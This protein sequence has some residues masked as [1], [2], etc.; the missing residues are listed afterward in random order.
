[1]FERAS[2]YR[3]TEGGAMSLPPPEHEDHVDARFKRH[4]CF[5]AE[6]MQAYGQACRDAALEEAA[7]DAERI[8]HLWSGAPAQAFFKLAEKIRS[9]K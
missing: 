9:L 4:S 2:R 5:T 7:I 6:Q 1:M 3:S 8:G